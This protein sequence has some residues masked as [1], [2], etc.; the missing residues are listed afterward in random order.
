MLA[1][2]PVVR[3]LKPTT[4][5]YVAGSPGYMTAG[6]LVR[7]VDSGRIP[8]PAGRV[9]G[10]EAATAALTLAL[11]TYASPRHRGKCAPVRS[12]TFVLQTGE[13]IFATGKLHIG[14]VF[15]GTM[16]APLPMARLHRFQAL[17]G[18]L[19]LSIER[20]PSEKKAILWRCAF[21][22]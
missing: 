19:P 7:G 16:S 20:Y 11:S 1:N 22:P 5:V 21:R 13:Q 12:N 17:T 3:D 10:L 9:T 8:K 14:Y 18:P 4:R 2:S 6:W 15:D